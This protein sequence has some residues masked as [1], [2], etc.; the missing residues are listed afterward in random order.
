MARTKITEARRPSQKKLGL[1]GGKKISRI[2]EN[3]TKK[4][5]VS[6]RAMASTRGRLSGGLNR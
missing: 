2:Q 3:P 5:K 1:A 4:A 6:G